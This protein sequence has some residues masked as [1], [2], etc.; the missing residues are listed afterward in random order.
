MSRKYLMQPDYPTHTI[1]LSPGLTRNQRA[2]NKTETGLRGL[3]NTH[4]S[5][6]Y[7]RWGT[8]SYNRIY[9]ITNKQKFPDVSFALRTVRT[10]EVA[11]G[12]L[13]RPDPG[14]KHQGCGV[15]VVPDLVEYRNDYSWNHSYFS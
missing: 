6:K 5:R 4:P 2:I 9:H 12:A 8:C 10:D 14:T 11:A 3:N 13:H 7:L 1:V 15:E